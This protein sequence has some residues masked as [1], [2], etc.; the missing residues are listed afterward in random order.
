M[1]D[2]L[3]GVIPLSK[4]G[5]IGRRHSSS[6]SSMDAQYRPLPQSPD[7]AQDIAIP[8]AIEEGEFSTEEMDDSIIDGHVPSDAPVDNRIQWIHSMLGSAVL[9]PWNG[10]SEAVS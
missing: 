5:T 9:L 8:S 2:S 6:L 10:A 4:S 3:S 7:V 1:S